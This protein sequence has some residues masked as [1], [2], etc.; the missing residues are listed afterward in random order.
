[1]VNGPFARKSKLMQELKNKEPEK[2]RLVA[3]LTASHYPYVM[4]THSEDNVQHCL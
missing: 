4:T 3:Y 2:A 1:V